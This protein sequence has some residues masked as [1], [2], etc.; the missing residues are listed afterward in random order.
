MKMLDNNS[1][2]NSVGPSA[3]DSIYNLGV[4]YSVCDSIFNLVCDSVWNSSLTNVRDLVEEL[5][6]ESIH[7]N[8]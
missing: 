4:K 8:A 6:K 7:E 2:Y 1:D 5:I 3:C